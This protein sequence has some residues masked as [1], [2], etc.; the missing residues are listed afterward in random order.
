MMVEKEWGNAG[1]AES[2]WNLPRQADWF[3]SVRKRA[4]AKE[5]EEGIFG[6]NFMATYLHTSTHR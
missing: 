1:V 6:S 2:R 5:E 3:L 4:T